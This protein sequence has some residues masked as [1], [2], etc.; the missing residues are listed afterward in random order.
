M[1]VRGCLRETLS[2]PCCSSYEMEGNNQPDYYKDKTLI[3]HMVA[4]YHYSYE[5]R[6]S[7]KPQ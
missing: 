7:R 6:N 4:E 1:G 5:T 3:N 2:G